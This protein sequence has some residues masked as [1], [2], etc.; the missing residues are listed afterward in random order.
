[1]RTP[2]IRSRALFALMAASG[3][4][5][6]SGASAAVIKQFRLQ[7]HPDGNA[8]PPAYGLRFDNL[9]T[10]IGGPSG[11]TTFSMNHFGN[12]ILS[13]IDNGGSLAINIK[14]TVF[15]G[16]DTGVAT[17]FGAGAYALNFTYTMNVGPSGTGWEVDPNSPGNTGTLTSL[18]N[19]DVAAGTVF[20]L[21]DKDGNQGHS[22]QFLQ[23]D[24]RLAGHSEFGQGY[25][26]G[27]GWVMNSKND[28]A[29]HDFLFLGTMLI[30]L[31]TP[32]GMAAAGLIGVAALRRRRS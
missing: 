32:L 4:A 5:C 22:F 1:M 26:V 15:G 10:T 24:H 12:T 31:P 8:L 18:G 25:W 29:T 19:A 23:D 9:F 17:G 13:V 7:D 3:L 11:I 14:G 16:V 27:R 21:A 28:S 2:T 30:P 6:A 20:D